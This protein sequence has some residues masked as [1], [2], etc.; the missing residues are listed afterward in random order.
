MLV[1]FLSAF[2]RHNLPW[3][4]LDPATTCYH[5]SSISF[6]M[7]QHPCYL[8]QW[9]C[10]QQ[11]CLVK[12]MVVLQIQHLWPSTPATI[13]LVVLQIQHPFAINNHLL[14][15]SLATV[16]LSHPK[17]LRVEIVRAIPRYDQK[18]KDLIGTPSASYWPSSTM[19]DP[20]VGSWLPLILK[21]PRS[22]L[23]KTIKHIKKT[24]SEIHHH[25]L[26]LTN[27]YELTI[28]LPIMDH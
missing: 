10:S 3:H 22:S 1:I 9:S 24:T 19:K 12:T 27:H 28:K 11:L 15:T 17:S 4:Q 18:Q 25:G 23:K 16:V 13:N 21:H 20:I 5:C 8:L 2:L 14:S 7:T 6:W 26:V